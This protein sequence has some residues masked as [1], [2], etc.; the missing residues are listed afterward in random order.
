LIVKNTL[1]TAME[2]SRC[3]RD[4]ARPTRESRPGAGLSK[5]NSVRRRG[6]R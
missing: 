6:R 3:A 5:L 1:C 4:K 2:F